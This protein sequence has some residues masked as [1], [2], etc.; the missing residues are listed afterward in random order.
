ME[1]A[2]YEVTKGVMMT[3]KGRD[4]FI[5]FQNKIGRQFNHFKRMIQLNECT[6]EELEQMVI[7][8]YGA[9]A[10]PY[11]NMSFSE[12]LDHFA[13]KSDSDEQIN[14][15][16]VIVDIFNDFFGQLRLYQENNEASEDA[17]KNIDAIEEKPVA[18]KTT[19][20]KP[21]AKKTTKRKPKKDNYE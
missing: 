3:I 17:V 12:S 4:E 10:N 14:D 13:N 11:S 1:L 21:V 16:Q 20:K 9:I 8:R 2:T 5:D 15:D 6:L 7:N 18:K 19:V